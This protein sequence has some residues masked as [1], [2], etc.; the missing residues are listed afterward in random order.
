MG[1]AIDDPVQ[2]AAVGLDHSSGTDVVLGAGDQDL[3]QAELV[4]DH[5]G[6]GEHLSG[7]AASP[8]TGYDVVRGPRATSLSD[9]CRGGV[10]GR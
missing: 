4:A 5:P 8:E 7:V 2:G 3:G 9:S 10:L 1:F 6:L